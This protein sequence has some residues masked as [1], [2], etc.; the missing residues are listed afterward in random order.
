MKGKRIHLEDYSLFKGIKKEEAINCVIEIEIGYLAIC[1]AFKKILIYAPKK[2]TDI[3]I[4]IKD[5]ESINYI[6][7]TK[8]EH[9][10][11]GTDKDI[12]IYTINL[13]NKSYNLFQTL[14][15]H[16]NSTLMLLELSNGKLVSS[17]SDSKIIIYNYKDNKYE[18]ELALDFGESNIECLIET[19]N[20]EICGS[21]HYFLGF[22]SIKN[23]YQFTK[24]TLL[25]AHGTGT[26]CMVSKELMAAINQSGHGFVLINV[27][28]HQ[29]IKRYYYKENIII[30]YLL[31][32]S[33]R[34]NLIAFQELWSK[35][36]PK[37]DSPFKCF[38]SDSEN[39]NV[40]LKQF[41]VIKEPKEQ[42]EEQIIKFIDTLYTK[43]ND[44][45][46]SLIELTNH[47][48]VTAC[49]Q[50]GI[51]SPTMYDKEYQ[52]QIFD[53]SKNPIFDFDKLNHSF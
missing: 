3:I 14:N 47:K 20:N 43:N 27:F 44:R 52:V 11:S 7:Y 41:T 46:T 28:S 24:I 1:G 31:H 25:V 23:N 35:H 33:D 16:K 17:A 34:S 29:I 2:Y 32:L 15:Y 8:H 38:F 51:D 21:S 9:L 49:F 18:L 53:K 42:S 5:N 6:I 40:Y 36:T 13:E 37:N 48:I 4:S 30:S 39:S 10:I 19:T 50:G 12:K 22:W 26:L 45:L